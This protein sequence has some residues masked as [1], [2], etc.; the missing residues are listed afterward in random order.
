MSLLSRF[1]KVNEI[2]SQFVDLGRMP[3]RQ[4]GARVR[5]IW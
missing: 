2:Q 5:L 3:S 4:L 1:R